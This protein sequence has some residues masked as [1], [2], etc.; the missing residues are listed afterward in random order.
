M[1]CNTKNGENLLQDEDFHFLYNYLFTWN[2][3]V[4]L[5]GRTLLCS[6]W[7]DLLILMEVSDKVKFEQREQ[8]SFPFASS[9]QR[10]AK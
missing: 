9:R 4:S 10:K 2:L 1:F 5:L 8:N 6:I 7:V 3:T